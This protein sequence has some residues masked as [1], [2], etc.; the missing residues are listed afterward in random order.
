MSTFKN[1]FTLFSPI[2]LQELDSVALF[3]RREE[4]FLI[5]DFWCEEISR[6][7]KSD[8]NILEIEGERRFRYDNLHFDTPDNICLEDHIRGRKNRYKVRIRS[9]SN[10]KISFL[11]VKS[12][13][14]YGRSSKMR[15]QRKSEQW[16]GPLTNEEKLF[17]SDCVPFASRLAPV[18]Y[19][20]YLRHTIASIPRGERITFD[21]NLEYTTLKGERFTPLD[22]LS[23][24]ELKQEEKDR[25]SSLHKIFRE[26]S[27]RRS[28]LGRTIRISKYVL[29][30]LHTNKTLSSRA[31]LESLKQLTRA[32]S[33]AENIIKITL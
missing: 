28:P 6:N 7:L 31:Y 24:V 16:D 18:L 17:L 20:N 2:S 33:V 30:R 4:K 29:G 3:D 25:R 32:S 27:D 22:G 5:P 13:N 12:R 11:E 1:Y 19:S 23:I 15:I 21:T 9:Y 26:R 14:V 8:Y 10:S